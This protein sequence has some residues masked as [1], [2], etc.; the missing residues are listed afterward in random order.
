MAWPLDALDITYVADR[1]VPSD[2]LNEI[3]QRI[4]DLHAV[5]QVT[6]FN[7]V[8]Q[9]NPPDWTQAAGLPEQGWEAVGAGGRLL[10]PIQLHGQNHIID[11]V[12]VKYYI[13][14]AVGLTIDLTLIDGKYD[15]AA[16]D[17]TAAGV[18]ATHTSA[19]GAPADWRVAEWTALAQ[20]VDDESFL[21]VRIANH[22]IGDRVLGA[23][24]QFQPITPT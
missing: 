19:G 16:T 21:V 17:P 18:G 5:H 9:G 11:E 23:Q 14:A 2:N 15:A 24:V 10:I 22:D 1:D 8:S 13:A 3:Q 7:G 20:T 6:F 12:R 4:V